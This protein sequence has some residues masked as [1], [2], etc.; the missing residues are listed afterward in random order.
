MKLR[1]PGCRHPG[2]WTSDGDLP[3]SIQFFFE[4]LIITWDVARADEIVETEGPEIKV[5]VGQ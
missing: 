1:R 5:R 3:K 2:H 4:K